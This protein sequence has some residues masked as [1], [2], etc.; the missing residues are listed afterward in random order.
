MALSA[1]SGR[2][3]LPCMQAC[4]HVYSCWA[5][6]HPGCLLFP[7]SP[8]RLLCLNGKGLLTLLNRGTP[9][10]RAAA[11]VYVHRRTVEVRRS[12]CCI[13]ALF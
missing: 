4:N 13:G 6:T 10:G 5:P 11:G 3:A 12:F 7:N 8:D 2:P 9:G 1:G